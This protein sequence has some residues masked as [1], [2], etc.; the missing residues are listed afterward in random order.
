MNAAE[1][2]GVWDAKTWEV[3]KRLF[4]YTRRYRTVG[5][6]AILGMAIDG[7]ALAVFTNLL[8]PLFDDLF[9]NKDP[10]LIF[11]MPIW[12]MIIFAVRG[13][14]T[15]LS[16]YG[17][18]Y[19]GRHVVQA[20]QV[21][22][23]GSY[24]K[25]PAPFFGAEPSGQQISRITYT[26][27]QV[28]S[29]STDAIKIAVTEGV[30]VVSMLYVMLHN[31]AYLTL[32][33]L[34]MVPAVALIATVVSRRYRSISRRIQGS[35]GSVTGTV[36]ESVGAYREVR[37]Y[38]GQPH[39]GARFDDVTRRA[40]RLNLKIALTSASSSTAIQTVAAF[41]LAVLVF[42]GTRADVIDHITSG[43]FITVLTAMG[44][45]IPSLKRLTNV[46][47]NIQRGMSAAEDLFDVMDMAPENDRGRIALDRTR[48][49]LVFEGIRLRYPRSEAEA[50]RGVLD[51]PQALL[52]PAL[53]GVHSYRRNGSPVANPD[54]LVF[55]RYQAGFPWRSS[56]EQLAGD[57]LALLGR[58]LPATELTALAAA[59]YRTDLYRDAAR[60]LGWPCPSCDHKPAGEHA[61]AYDL[62][63]GVRLGA[64]RV[65]VAATAS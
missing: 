33:L 57:C 30:T 24:L 7:G 51:L 1:R 23:F 13:V 58:T 22:V 11:W 40:R 46:Q 63:P 43:V 49:D 55:H 29:A 28:A 5:L 10:H 45:M 41:A 52:L 37:I 32:A 15:F 3:Y 34:V 53:L 16:S 50:L 47:S 56:A 64:D 31:S 6:L 39:E 20:M 54:F 26:S 61:E 42:L 36:E 21:D 38:G 60:V 62:E 48:G 2:R 14:G 12:I 59:C 8:R 18:S 35:M 44:A 65:M 25:L 4:G 19:I 9:K 17:I 27:E